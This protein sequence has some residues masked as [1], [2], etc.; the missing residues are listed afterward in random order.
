ML[1]SSAQNCGSIES[2]FYGDVAEALVTDNQTVYFHYVFSADPL[3]DAQVHRDSDVGAEGVTGET[4][5][6]QDSLTPCSPSTEESG[7]PSPMSH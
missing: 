7:P 1:W 4:G 3:K 2:L 5:R 6:F